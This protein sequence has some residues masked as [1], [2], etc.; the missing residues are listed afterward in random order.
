MGI[1]IPRNYKRKVGARVYTVTSH[2]TLSKA[3]E[4]YQ[5]GSSQRVAC[6]KLKYSIAR[7]R[8]QNFIKEKKGEIISSLS[9]HPTVLLKEAE[10]EI[11]EHLLTVSEWGFPFN[12]I[13]LRMTVKRLLEKEGT[14][15]YIYIFKENLTG[16]DWAQSFL[17]RHKDRLKNRLYRNIA[18]KSIHESRHNK[19][20]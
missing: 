14:N 12:N 2:E 3:F 17:K 16:E 8:F 5:N 9:G 11:V 1:V 7:S 6:A 20:I 10:C 15:I 13:D 19:G 18:K 4:E